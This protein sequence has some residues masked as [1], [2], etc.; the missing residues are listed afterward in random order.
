MTTKKAIIG[1]L[2]SVE[3]DG[4]GDLINFLEESTFYTD[5]ATCSD[6]NNYEGGLADHCL[7]TYQLLTRYCVTCANKTPIKDIPE[8]S[9]KIIGLLHDIS[10]VGTFQK[11]SK[12]VTVVGKDGKNRTKENGKLL[13]IEKD[14]YDPIPSHLPY[15]SGQLSPQ[16]L[17]KYI[18]IT[19]LE[20]L[21]IQWCEG[22][23]DLTHNQRDI[24]RRAQ[25]M[26]Q[27]VLYTQFAKRE[28]SLFFG[29]KS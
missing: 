16:L 3:R 5:P 9:L 18:K 26:H 28:A 25:R 14:G 2:S 7:N 11:V 17:K 13:F 10:K 24:V 4:M 12:N 1:L 20:D 29:K 8:D 22:E 21:A 15:F 27:V 23:S 6:H 19:K